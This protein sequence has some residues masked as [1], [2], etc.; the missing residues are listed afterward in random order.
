MPEYELISSDSHTPTGSARS[1]TSSTGPLPSAAPFCQR[2]VP[3]FLAAL[4]AGLAA[5]FALVY[6]TGHFVPVPLTRHIG[7]QADKM[8][9]KRTVGYFVRLVPV[10]YRYRLA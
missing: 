7:G 8:E 4:L 6:Q 10:S 5:Y 9:G 2:P 3:F 1:H